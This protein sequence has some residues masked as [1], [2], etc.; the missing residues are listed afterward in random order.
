LLG[1]DHDISKY[2]TAVTKQTSMFPLQQLDTMKVTVFS[3]GPC[4]N[5]VRRT[6]LEFVSQLRAAL[7]EVRDSS[8]TQRKGTPAVG[9]RY[10]ETGEDTAG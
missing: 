6:N 3:S 7:A 10:Q 8:G 4:R 5:V 9:S 2:T 1:N